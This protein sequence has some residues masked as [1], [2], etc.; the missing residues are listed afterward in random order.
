M[1]RELL[2]GLAVVFMASSVI[3]SNIFRSTRSDKPQLPVKNASDSASTTA[4][5]D[6]PAPEPESNFKPTDV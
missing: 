2:T 6:V 4:G 3:I 1:L 5:R